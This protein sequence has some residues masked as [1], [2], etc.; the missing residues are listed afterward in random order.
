MQ[1]SYLFAL[2]M[3]TILYV[4]NKHFD[5]KREPAL[6]FS[7]RG[8]VMGSRPMKGEK[9]MHR[10]IKVMNCCICPTVDSLFSLRVS[11]T[12]VKVRAFVCLEH[13]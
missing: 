1:M 8:D 3:G 13:R 7:Q 6:V 10:L 5:S 9:K 12:T 4:R 2:R 11:A